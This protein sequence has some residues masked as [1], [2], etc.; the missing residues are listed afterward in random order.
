MGVIAA[1][2]AGVALSV[3]VLLI[4]TALLPARAEAEQVVKT[5]VDVRQ[6]GSRNHKPI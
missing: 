6:L 1:I 3:G 5:R 4:V 2:V